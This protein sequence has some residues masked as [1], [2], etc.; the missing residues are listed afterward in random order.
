MG[1]KRT[2]SKPSGSRQKLTKHDYTKTLKDRRLILETLIECLV[3]NDTES[4]QDVLVAHLRT[5]SKSK[6][7]VETKLGRQ[8][9]YDL[10]DR[11]KPFNPTL[12]TIGSILQSLAA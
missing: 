12:T 4:F 5:V 10:L 1:K 11:N 9:L 7:A 2:S 6:L 3:E 8:T